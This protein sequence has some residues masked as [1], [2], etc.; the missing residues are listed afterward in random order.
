MGSLSRSDRKKLMRDVRGDAPQITRQCCFMHDIERRCQN[1]A[2][3]ELIDSNEQRPDMAT[4]D[5]CA[6]HVGAL[7]GSNPPTKPAGPWI[8]RLI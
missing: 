2:E 6:D 1:M 5:A 7:L 4:I 3:Y 8:V